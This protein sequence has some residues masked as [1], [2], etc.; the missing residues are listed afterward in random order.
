[1]SRRGDTGLR[2]VVYA[3]QQA[4]KYVQPLYDAEKLLREIASF[5]QEAKATPGMLRKSREKIRQYEEKLT[6][7][8][9]EIIVAGD[10]LDRLT[11]NMP[12]INKH[13]SILEDY[14]EVGRILIPLKMDLHDCTEELCEAILTKT[15]ELR[16]KVN[17]YIKGECAFNPSSRDLALVAND[18]A[19]C[20]HRF[21]DWLTQNVAGESMP[22][23]PKC[24]ILAGANETIKEACKEWN[25]LSDY[26]NSVGL[27][28]EVDYTPLQG[29][30]QNDRLYLRVGSAGGHATELNLKEGKIRYYDYDEP[31]NIA[32]EELFEDQAGVTCSRKEDGVECSELT[33]N[34]I[35]EA[36]RAAAAATSMDFR[37]RHPASYWRRNA[38]T[39]EVYDSALNV[40]RPDIES[41]AMHYLI[42][43]WMSKVRKS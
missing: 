5:L 23:A 32:M 4:S 3:Q 28:Q 35:K 15:D 17:R 20:I 30:A 14:G 38:E 11:E 22:D 16:S 34:N 42:D 41:Q 18:V 40:R 21:A 25:K 7:L 27:Y 8:N 43:Y 36:A 24:Y 9:R 19:S 6:D 29:V 33:E 1:M 2:V 12:M 13:H 37:I 26:F 39:N 10:A 31:V